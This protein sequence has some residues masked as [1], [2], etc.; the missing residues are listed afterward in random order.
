MKTCVRSW[1]E[2][3]DPNHPTLLSVVVAASMLGFNLVK[4][5]QHYLVLYILYTANMGQGKKAAQ[6]AP[7]HVIL[8]LEGGGSGTRCYASS[9]TGCSDYHGQHSR[10]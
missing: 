9:I 2:G 6:V 10:P 5:E 4:L 7:K 1:K 8:D 3:D